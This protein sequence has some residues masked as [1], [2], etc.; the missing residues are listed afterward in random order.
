MCET[1]QIPSSLIFPFALSALPD[2]AVGGVHDGD[3][4]VDHQDAHDDLVDQPD[5]DAST[6]GELKGEIFVAA[7]IFHMNCFGIVSVQHSP[8]RGDN[9][10]PSSPEGLFIIHGDQGVVGC[11]VLLTGILERLEQGP[12]THGMGA[13]DD[14]VDEGN[15]EDVLEHPGDADDDLAQGFDEEDPS[16]YP[17]QE[18]VN[19][20]D[21]RKY[22]T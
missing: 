9:E 8:D 21:E 13:P 20:D 22:G 15:A 17:K 16:H 4:Y 5:G 3:Q 2:L 19:V 1:H 6:V 11:A 14:Q 7:R 18:K 10:T 12:G